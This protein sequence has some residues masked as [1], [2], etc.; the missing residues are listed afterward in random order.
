MD[1]KIPELSLIVLIGVSGSG[2]STFA[3]KHFQPTEVISSDTCRGLVSDDETDQSAT[4]DAFEVLHFIAAKRLAGRRL[5]VID[6]TNVKAEDR[7]PLLKLAKQYH[8]FSVA[9]AFNLPPKLCQERNK[10]RSNRQFSSQVVHRQ[11]QYLRRGLNKL[12]REGFRYHYIL[13]SVEGIDKVSIH[14]QPLGHNLRQEHGP[15]DIIGDIHGCYDELE[16]LLQNLGYQ[17]TAHPDPSSGW[18]GPIYHHLLV[19]SDQ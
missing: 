6:A 18:Y 17:I 3:R 12:K 5:T 2:K 7:K 11:S 15:F 13:S 1:I 4:K 9:I 14:R 10:N 16:T 8:F 19:T